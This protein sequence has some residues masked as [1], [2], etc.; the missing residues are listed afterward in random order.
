MY[1]MQNFF[2][3]TLEDLESAIASLGNERYRAKQLY[4]WIY[5]QGVFD[6]NAMT[7]IPK[8]L[9]N[10]FHDM[11]STK[12]V[13]IQEALESADG[14]KKFAFLLED[15]NIIEGILIPEKDRNT[16]C[17]SSQVGCR[18][19]C[20][21]CVTGQIGFKRNLHP[22]E[23]VGQIVAVKEHIRESEN[24][25]ISN[26]VFMGMGEPMDNLD[27]VLKALDII[28]HPL[29]LDF[30]HRKITV[31]SVGL[32]EGLISLESKTACIALSLNASNNETRSRIMP[33]NR[34][35]PI[36]RLIDFV[37]SFK[38][39]NRV[40]ITFEYV[41]IKDVNDSLENAR[42]LAEL[43]KNV[44]C[45]INLIPYNE[46]PH[47]EFKAPGEASVLRFRDYLAERH[48]TAMVRDSKGR[49]VSGACGQLGMRYLKDY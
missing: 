20:R 5:N 24:N 8:S 48:F 6:F 18:M 14:S 23:I 32:V 42:E 44:K 9:R 2:G 25:R 10:I 37:K 40:R 11:F 41:L 30:S 19:G 26:I 43:L 45:K 15:G 1:R 35:Y 3:L 33:I 46:S 29:G 22:S 12:P 4:R 27:S 16:L 47:I 13:L 7:N 21:F 31:S 34:L 38:S 28:K 49:D 39:S 36:E 17:I